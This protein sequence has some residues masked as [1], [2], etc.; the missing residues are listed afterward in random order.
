MIMREIEFPLRLQDE[1]LVDADHGW[2]KILATTRDKEF[3]SSI[4]E[5]VEES[6]YPL[7]GE[8]IYQNDDG[9]FV[10]N[11]DIYGD[12]LTL[13]PTVFWGYVLLS[14]ERHCSYKRDGYEQCPALIEA[15]HQKIQ[16]AEK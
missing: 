16:E 7:E 8:I 15:V 12:V 5:L 10:V 3:V 6:L 9:D 2:I 4:T 1:D 14:V 11:I 13:D